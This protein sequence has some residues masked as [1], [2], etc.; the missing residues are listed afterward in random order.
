MQMIQ[1]QALADAARLAPRYPVSVSK[2]GEQCYRAVPDDFAYMQSFGGTPE[3]ARKHALHLVI[4]A[5]ACR[6]QN[7][8]EIPPV[9]P[10]AH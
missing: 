6:I 5:L 2:L 4:T 9:M 10:E 3:D 1:P 8:R 7:K